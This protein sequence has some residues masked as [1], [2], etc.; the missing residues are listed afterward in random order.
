MIELLVI[1]GMS[2]VDFELCV[3]GGDPRQCSGLVC[4]GQT[5]WKRKKNKVGLLRCLCRHGIMVLKIMYEGLGLLIA[6]GAH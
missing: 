5:V 2:E 1:R 4:D 3:V 6:R